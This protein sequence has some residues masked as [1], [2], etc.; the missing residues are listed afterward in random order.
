MVTDRTTP[1]GAEAHMAAILGQ[2]FPQFRITRVPSGVWFATRLRP[3][4]PEE[5]ARGLHYCLARPG[6]IH[7]I[8]ALEDQVGILHRHIAG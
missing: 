8:L 5:R 2:T 4:T 1:A 6:L 7:L 3:V